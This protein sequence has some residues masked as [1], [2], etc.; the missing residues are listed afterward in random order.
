MRLLAFILLLASCCDTH[1]QLV[2]VPIISDQNYVI[3]Q[4]YGAPDPNMGNNGDYY[5]NVANDE[6]Y[7]PKSN[8]GWGKPVHLV[9]RV[10]L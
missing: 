4:G 6:I 9:E 8:D 5:F 7:G 1:A 3:L 10:R 2:T